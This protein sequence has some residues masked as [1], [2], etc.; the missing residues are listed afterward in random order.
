MYFEGTDYYYGGV[1]I[2][3]CA[4]TRGKVKRVERQDSGTRI[5]W[6]ECRTVVQGES[7]KDIH[8]LQMA[9]SYP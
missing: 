1:A 2:D 9:T 5:K 4:D 7:C 6:N 8:L 3:Q